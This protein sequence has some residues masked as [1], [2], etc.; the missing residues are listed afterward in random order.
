MKIYIYGSMAYDR[1]MGFPDK[2]AAHIL[3]ESI[4]R[5]NVA[6]NMTHLVEK[7]G[8][9]AGNIA[10]SL[11]LLGEAPTIIAAVGPDFDRYA[12]RLEQNGLSR[13]GI[14]T[15]ETEFTAGAYIATDSDNNQIT[16]FNLGAMKERCDFTLKNDEKSLVIISPGNPDDMLHYSRSCKTLQIPY[17]FD[18]G[19]AIPVLSGKMIAAM[20]KGSFMVITNDYE[21]ELIARKTNLRQDAIM[22]QTGVLVTT[23]GAEGAL[24][25]EKG[26]ETRIPPA[27]VKKAIDPTGAGDAFRSGLIKGL[28]LEKEV[29]D[30]AKM[31]TV[32][33]AFCVEKEGT[34]EHHFTL[35]EFERRLKSFEA[36]RHGA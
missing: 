21:M 14:K 35:E 16:F 1:I 20:I 32:C 18:P 7:F 24:I 33:A 19:Q 8:G 12:T 29:I 9:T 2:F 11:A 23:L 13:D 17:I 30:A 6:F 22:D 5:L 34:Q 36:G 26:G 28:I 4:D 15:V 3:P 27:V 25:R 31:G 10:Y